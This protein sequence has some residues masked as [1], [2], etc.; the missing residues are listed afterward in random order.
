MNY[1]RRSDVSSPTN[2]LRASTMFICKPGLLAACDWSW[3]L[4][5]K[6]EGETERQTDR[7][8]DRQ[9]EKEREREREREEKRRERIHEV[10]RANGHSRSRLDYLL[11][12]C[13][14][15]SL[16]LVTG[17]C[18][19]QIGINHRVRVACQMRKNRSQM[20]VQFI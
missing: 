3:L 1:L 7:Q 6:R 16:V 8:T 17:L 5:Y 11:Q 19:K 12:D 14:H 15:S 2:L 20:K 10:K 13:V 18:A 9:T 4:T